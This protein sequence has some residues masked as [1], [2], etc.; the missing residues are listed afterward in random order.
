MIFHTE[1][2][3]LLK[4]FMILNVFCLDALVIENHLALIVD[5]IQH[6]LEGVTIVG[7]RTDQNHLQV[8]TI[9]CFSVQINI[10]G[11]RLLLLWYREA[12]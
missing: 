7:Y 11:Y 10:L 9:Q 8:K 3:I 2:S 12:G 1:L 6:I 4:Y 5:K